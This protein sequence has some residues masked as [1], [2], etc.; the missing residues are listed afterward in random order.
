MRMALLT[1]GHANR[2]AMEAVL[3]RAAAQRIDRY[4][5]LGDFVGYDA[6]PAWVVDTV[7]RLVAGGAIAVL[8]NHDQAVAGDDMG[9]ER[10]SSRRTLRKRHAP[11]RP[12]AARIPPP[13]P[14]CQNST[15]HASRDCIMDVEHIN[16]IGNR[17]ADLTQRTEDL[18]GYL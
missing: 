4:A 16:A 13:Q 2:E 18:R 17:L 5:L 8:G 15:F 14:P 3:D 9:T 10:L 7:R 6:E 12:M 11:M 1:D